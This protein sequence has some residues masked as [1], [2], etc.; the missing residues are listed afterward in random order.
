MAGYRPHVPH[1][2][3]V[4]DLHTAFLGVRVG[5]ARGVSCE[6]RLTDRRNRPNRREDAADRE[7]RHSARNTHRCS[8]PRIGAFTW[9]WDCEGEN[10]AR[11][12]TTRSHVNPKTRAEA[13]T[14][15]DHAQRCDLSPPHHVT[16]SASRGHRPERSRVPS[17]RGASDRRVDFCISRHRSPSRRCPRPRR[18][19]P[20]LPSDWQF[21]QRHHEVGGN[22]HAR[23]RGP[24]GPQRGAQHLRCRPRRHP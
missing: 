7:A 19:A 23:S 1:E 4:V 22:R 9:F 16:G 18:P 12:P 15:S 20:A 24:V 13:R 8:E 5:V 11:R 21:N 3:I 2:I 17:R 10:D 6:C 14:R